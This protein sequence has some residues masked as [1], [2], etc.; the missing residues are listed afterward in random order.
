[1]SRKIFNGPAPRNIGGTI[2]LP[3]GRMLLF[4]VCRPTKILVNIVDANIDFVTLAAL[5]AL[6][7]YSDARQIELNKLSN[8]GPGSWY[9]GSRTGLPLEGPFLVYTAAKPSLQAQ[10]EHALRSQN[11]ESDPWFVRTLGAFDNTDACSWVFDLAVRRPLYLPY[12]GEVEILGNLPGTWTVEAWALQLGMSDVPSMID[13]EI[14]L[15][16]QVAPP[17]GGGASFRVFG[18]I[19]RGAHSYTYRDSGVALGAFPVTEIQL[20]DQAK[21][22][23]N[24]ATGTPL[25]GI[26]HLNDYN[27]Q[28]SQ[29]YG[30]WGLANAM[31]LKQLGSANG[32]SGE[33]QFHLSIM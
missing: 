29:F 26:P 2:L 14:T 6:P 21:N 23:A 10:E 3:W 28:S 19:P 32:V 27:N 4:S 5:P 9:D 31:R 11:G 13:A 15:T 24:A 18:G 12:P 7:S 20:D 25:I 1:M 22:D 33:F 16:A 8:G 17:S 30:R